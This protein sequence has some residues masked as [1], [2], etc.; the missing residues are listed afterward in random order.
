MDQDTYRCLNSGRNTVGSRKFE[1]LGT[2]DFISKYRKFELL[3][4]RNKSIQPSKMIIFQFF[5]YQTCFVYV[6]EMS[7]GDVSITLKKHVF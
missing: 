1:V 7:Q 4:G 3:G 2:R 6:K 5:P